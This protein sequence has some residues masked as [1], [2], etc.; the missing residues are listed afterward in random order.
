M[1]VAGT[2]WLVDLPRSWCFEHGLLAVALGRF[3]R[4]LR[5]SMIRRVA[6]LPSCPTTICDTHNNGDEERDR[7]QDGEEGEG[8]FFRFFV[9][10]AR[11]LRRRDEEAHGSKSCVK[12]A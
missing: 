7:Q 9:A 4:I 12:N 1:A 10:T 6:V 2:D 3:A 11:R 5:R 8:Y